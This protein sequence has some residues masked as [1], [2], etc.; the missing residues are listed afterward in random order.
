MVS[1]SWMRKMR[2]SRLSINWDENKT[3]ILHS[4]MTLLTSFI[5][6]PYAPLV[7]PWVYQ[8][9]KH[10]APKIWFGSLS[11][12]SADLVVFFLLYRTPGFLP[13]Y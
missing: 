1:F 6:L 10:T 13:S 8:Q 12:N 2:V 3:M 9:Q 4:I 5:E 7:L 11:V